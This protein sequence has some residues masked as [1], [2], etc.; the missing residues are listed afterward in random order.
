[1]AQGG[2]GERVADGQAECVSRLSNFTWEVLFTQ[3]LEHYLNPQF[4]ECSHTNLVAC[5]QSECADDLRRDAN[6]KAIASFRDAHDFHPKKIQTR[7]IRPKINL[8]ASKPSRYS[9]NDS[10]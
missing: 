5:L 1:M 9:K 2:S 7:I 4:I 8:F 3:R 6:G 10:L